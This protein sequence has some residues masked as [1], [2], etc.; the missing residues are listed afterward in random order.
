MSNAMQE[1]GAETGSTAEQ[2]IAGP[3][4]PL[5]QT[6]KSRTT[7]VGLSTVVDNSRARLT[8]WGGGH[9]MT[10]LCTYD[11]A[12]HSATRARTTLRSA[13]DWMRDTPSPSPSL[14]HRTPAL[15]PPRPVPR[16]PPFVLAPS[17]PRTFEP[18]LA[19]EGAGTQSSGRVLTHPHAVRARHNGTPLVLQGNGLIGCPEERMGRGG[20]GS[21]V[22]PPAAPRAKRPATR[23]TTHASVPLDDP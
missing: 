6:P 18:P 3:G 9:S 17:A 19:E 15:S 16:R 11:K 21:L 14:A 13:W 8:R 1:D 4:T 23:R 20:G 2:S 5:S 10:G 7:F 12:H 22:Q